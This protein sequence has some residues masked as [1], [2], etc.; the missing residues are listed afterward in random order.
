MIQDLFKYF[1]C[2]RGIATRVS[3]AITNSGVG[4]SAI[5]DAIV[6]CHAITSSGVGF[7]IDAIIA[8]SS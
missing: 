1:F 3:D 4:F 7:G 2:I 8:C 5:G 6:G